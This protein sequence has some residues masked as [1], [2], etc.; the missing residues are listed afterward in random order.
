MNGV[1][2]TRPWVPSRAA[3]IHRG[4]A[5]QPG[6]ASV[7][8]AD[9]TSRALLVACLAAAGCAHAGPDLEGMIPIAAGSFRSGSS[10]DDRALA[11]DD[12]VRNGVDM[13]GV[14]ERLRVE[15]VEQRIRTAAFAVMIHPVTQAEYAAYVYATGAAE[16]W[17]DADTW[18]RTPHEPAGDLDAV[19]WKDGRPRRELMQ[20]PAVLVSQPEAAAYCRWW[21]EQRGGEGALPSVAQWERVA[22]GSEGDAYPWGDRFVP[23][24]ANTRE[25]GGRGLEV[26][27]LHPAAAGPE[28]V[29]D[30]AGNVAEWTRTVVGDRAV[31]KGSA[32]TDD[33]V[34][35]RVTTRRE[36]PIVARHPAIG[37]R[38][39]LALG[40]RRV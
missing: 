24:L 18:Q 37:F 10:L 40:S 3:A 1:V 36:M 27:G 34:A 32:W 7:D 2:T 8:V 33:L 23:S 39:V 31:I 5:V 28:G 6:L 26:V 13:A 21:G 16:P 11:I 29:Q 25:S 19:T 20:A 14:A 15:S 30:L 4:S 17:I 38:C 35:T 9:V 12:A 22:G